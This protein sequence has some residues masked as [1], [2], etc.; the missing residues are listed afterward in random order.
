V[1][2]GGYDDLEVGDINGDGRD[3]VIVMSG[4]LYAD[5]DLGVLLQTPEGSMNGPF[6]Y[7]LGG[8]QLTSGV[9]VGDVTG[10]GLNDVVV[11]YGGNRPSSSIAVFP[12][13]ALGT[14]G[15]PVSLASYDIPEPVE[16]A[17]LD[18]D[19]RQDVVVLHGGWNELGVYLQRPDG[20]L[21]PAEQLYPIPYASHYNPHGLAVGDL[22]G[23]GAPDIAIADYNN[24]LVVLYGT[25][26]VGGADFHTVKPCRV[27][28][29]RN[30][31]A[32]LGGP[33]LATGSDRTFRIAGTCDIPPTARAVSV[34]MA[35]T[36]STE[37]GH[38]RLHPAGASVPTAS[39][40]N[41]S[42]RMTRANNAIVD[43][44]DMGELGV[45]VGGAP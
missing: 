15:P 7:D 19:G 13:T 31:N 41:Y 38:L 29:T 45:F 9:G 32:S 42:P 20:T 12:Q 30:P 6:Y 8:D 34:V 40:V 35:V 23:D 24:G 14:L 27:V 33:A 18:G 37:F 39:T 25:G 17:D 11:S 2:H 44:N 22:N 4:Q 10:D 43:L 21:D 3:D 36:Q 28:D 16:I 1:A 5:D 26:P